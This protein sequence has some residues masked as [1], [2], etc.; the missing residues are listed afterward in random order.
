M[1]NFVEPY[2]AK[3]VL[4]VAHPLVGCYSSFNKSLVSTFA[5]TVPIVLLVDEK[6]GSM[7]LKVMCI[8]RMSTVVIVVLFRDGSFG[9]GFFRV[10]V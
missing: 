8:S 4:S 10:V 6:K 2:A 5:P 9:G 7:N 1:V 3:N